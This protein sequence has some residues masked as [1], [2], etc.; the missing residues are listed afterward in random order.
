MEEEKRKAGRPKKETI[1]G[2][3]RVEELKKGIEEEENNLQQLMDEKENL[4]K[5]Y[6]EMIESEKEELKN[7]RLDLEIKK[8]QDKLRGEGKLMTMARFIFHYVEQP[9]GVLPFTKQL[10]RYEVK[11]GEE[12]TYPKEIADHINSL[13]RPDRALERTGDG[14][15]QLRT[16]GKL[17]RCTATIIE[18]FEKEY[19]PK[20]DIPDQTKW[21]SKTAHII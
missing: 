2:S 3:I 7:F 1:E 11:D 16:I 5:E 17:P 9:G 20:T 18:T 14:Q 13:S 4:R 15:A 19:D 6:D 8:Q 10:I 21:R 12:Y